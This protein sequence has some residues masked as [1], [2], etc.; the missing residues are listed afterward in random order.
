MRGLPSRRRPASSNTPD[1]SSTCSRRLCAPRRNRSP[2][3]RNADRADD[4][5]RRQ[6]SVQR[7]HRHP[8]SRPHAGA[9]RAAW[10]VQPDDQ[11]DR[12][13][14]RRSASHGRRSRH[15]ARRGRLAG[16]RQPSRHQPRRLLRDADGRNAGGRCDRPRRATAHG[17]RPE[18][19]RRSAS[20]IC[21]PSS[22]TISSKGL[23]SARARTCTSRCST[24]DRTITRSKRCSRHS[25]GR[26]A[27]RARRTS[28]SRGCCRAR[29]G[30]CRANRKVRTTSDKRHD[31][32]H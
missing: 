8:V 30:C 28:G 16:A 27:S 22:C 15:R 24:A 7:Q 29:R 14:G 6:G 12:R 9:V 18:G 2:D 11:G 31:C 5:T 3:D 25:H 1:G 20:A 10:G 13:P 26:C 19:E 17:G 32:A 23:R 4:W 21:R